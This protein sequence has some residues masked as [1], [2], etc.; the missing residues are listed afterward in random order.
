MEENELNV[1]SSLRG[2]ERVGRTDAGRVPAFH[3]HV[4]FDH[5]KSEHA[6]GLPSELKSG[7][8][9][10]LC[11]GEQ[12]RHIFPGRRGGSAENGDQDD[13]MAKPLPEHNTVCSGDVRRFVERP[14]PEAEAVHAVANN[15]RACAQYRLNCLRVLLLRV[16]DGDSRYC[17]DSPICCFR[18]SS[19]T[20][21]SRVRVRGGYKHSEFMADFTIAHF[22]SR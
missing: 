8:D 6:K 1:K 19:G 9:G 5:T 14:E 10:V 11:P 13:V 15:R 2:P 12:K 4:Q 18:W 16:A 17:R 7:P 21:T 3:D 20:D 22:T